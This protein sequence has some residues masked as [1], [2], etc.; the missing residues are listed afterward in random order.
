MYD[1]RLKGHRMFFLYNLWRFSA[2]TLRIL[3][4]IFTLKSSSNNGMKVHQ[5]L[6]VEEAVL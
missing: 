3:K 1:C 4:K 6:T 5:K 2:V